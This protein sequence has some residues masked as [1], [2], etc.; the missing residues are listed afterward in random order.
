MENHGAVIDNIY[1][2]SSASGDRL[3]DCRNGLPVRLTYGARQD[4]EKD[5]SGGSKMGGKGGE[6]LPRFPHVLGNFDRIQD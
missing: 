4:A 2:G 1:L 5:M 6:Q 3:R